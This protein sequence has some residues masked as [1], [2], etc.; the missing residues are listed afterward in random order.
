MSALDLGPTECDYVH[1]SN[2]NDCYCSEQNLFFMMDEKVSLGFY[3]E[4]EPTWGKEQ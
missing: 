3:Q 2:Y 1:L 4:M